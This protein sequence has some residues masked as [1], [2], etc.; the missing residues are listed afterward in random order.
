MATESLLPYIDEKRPIEPEADGLHV[1]GTP[2][3]YTRTK[4]R[5]AGLSRPKKIALG[6]VIAWATF[7]AVSFGHH[8]HHRHHHG[9]HESKVGKDPRGSS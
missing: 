5:L 6:A 2:T 8:H 9:K 3:V 1:G 4:S 7:S